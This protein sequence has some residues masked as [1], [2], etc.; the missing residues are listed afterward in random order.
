MTNK[1]N[2][3]EQRQ[4]QTNGE[5]IPNYYLICGPKKES[6]LFSKRSLSTSYKMNLF[7]KSLLSIQYQSFGVKHHPFHSIHRLYRLGIWKHFT[8]CDDFDL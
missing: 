8:G 5:E 2:D 1:G 6:V 7:L 3:L 4:I